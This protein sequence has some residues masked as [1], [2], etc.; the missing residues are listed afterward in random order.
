MNLIAARWQR[1]ELHTRLDKAAIKIHVNRTVYK[2]LKS[3]SSLI[4]ENSDR[5]SLTD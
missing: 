2:L 1:K 4:E 3:F 5:Q